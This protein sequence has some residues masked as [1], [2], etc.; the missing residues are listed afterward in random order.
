MSPH[1]IK[2]CPEP[3]SAFVR[4]LISN[5]HQ[6]SAIDFVIHY[7]R[8]IM[9]IIVE[10]SA[11]ECMDV[12]KGTCLLLEPCLFSQFPRCAG[13]PFFTYFQ[14][15]SRQTEQSAVFSSSQKY[16]IF[17]WMCQEHPH[18]YTGY[19]KF[20]L[21]IPSILFISIYTSFF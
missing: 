3:S 11:V 16:F 21:E 12:L 14:P 18:P 8:Y 19:F 10:E 13:L 6:L 2:A 1:F 17:S 15:S 7:T 4:F 20:R 5:V 9:V